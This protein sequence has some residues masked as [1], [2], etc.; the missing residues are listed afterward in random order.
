MR[1][2]IALINL[3]RCD[4]FIKECARDFSFQGLCKTLITQEIDSQKRC[5][6]AKVVN[7]TYVSLN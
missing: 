2:I 3:Q 7:L 6:T 1:G 5:Y 4:S